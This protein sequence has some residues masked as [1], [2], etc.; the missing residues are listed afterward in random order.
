[1]V[2]EEFEGVVLRVV[3]I[4]DRAGDGPGWVEL[5]RMALA[6]PGFGVEVNRD[7]SVSN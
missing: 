3:P 5:E 6:S 1:M 4:W 7:A 2:L